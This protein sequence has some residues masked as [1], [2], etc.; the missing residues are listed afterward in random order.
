MTREQAKELCNLFPR[1]AYTRDVGMGSTDDSDYL[2]GRLKSLFPEFNWRVILDRSGEHTRWVLTIDDNDP[3]EHYFDRLGGQCI[4][5]GKSA[6]EI[7][8]ID[9]VNGDDVFLSEL[10]AVVKEQFVKNPRPQCGGL[11][12]PERFQ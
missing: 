12:I 9:E 7:A 6:R 5:C 2:C 8:R 1:S 10:E 4:H 11:I 3:R